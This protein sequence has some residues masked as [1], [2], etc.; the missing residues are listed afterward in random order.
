M[1][2]RQKLLD[3]I[4][5]LLAKTTGAGCTEQEAFSALAKAQELMDAY[6][7]RASDLK[8]P[9]EAITINTQ[10]KMDRYQIRPTIAYG[11]AT[12][13]DIRAWKD[14]PKGKKSTVAFAGPEG[15]VIFAYWL[16]DTLVNFCE[17][18][19][20]EYLLTNPDVETF[21]YINIESFSFG[22]AARIRERLK[23]LASHRLPQVQSNALVVSRQG[24][25]SKALQDA[26]IHL[27]GG[28]PDNRG[29]AADSFNAGRARGDSATFNRP[30]HGQ[31][32]GPLMIGRT[33]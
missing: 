5:A 26:G 10:Q 27:H 33:K 11:I 1:S 18:G 13:L 21:G 29:I 24:L 17:V 30:V 6:D 31:G 23:E 9:E 28:R 22:C 20:T 7:L 8:E 25:I 4:R 3:K 12:F 32:P 16:L 2:Q 15:D 14:K 19:A